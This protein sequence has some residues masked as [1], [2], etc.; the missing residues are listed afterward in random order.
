MEKT[1]VL[2]WGKQAL[3]TLSRPEA[4][5]PSSPLQTLQPKPRH[6]KHLLHSRNMLCSSIAFALC[7]SC[8][9]FLEY[10]SLLLPWAKAGGMGRRFDYPTKELGLDPDG[11]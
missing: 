6:A 7:K 4:T 9:L 3:H 8:A 10:P 2:N 11:W 1:L 5:F